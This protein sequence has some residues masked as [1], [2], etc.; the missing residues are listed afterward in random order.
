MFLTP[1]DQFATHPQWSWSGSPA[2]PLTTGYAVCWGFT[3]LFALASIVANV[4]FHNLYTFTAPELVL[5]LFEQGEMPLTQYLFGPQPSPRR[6]SLFHLTLQVV[7]LGGKCGSVSQLGRFCSIAATTWFLA[8]ILF[9]IYYVYPLSIF[10]LLA[11]FTFCLWFIAIRGHRDRFLTTMT[12][13]VKE[14]DGNVES[15]HLRW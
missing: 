7:S 2:T 6:D 5:G 14:Y 11:A 10:L 12:R 13:L 1:A 9:T 8:S 4:T 15:F 3:S